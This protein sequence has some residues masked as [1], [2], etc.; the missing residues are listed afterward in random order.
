MLGRRL[1]TGKIV[2]ALPIR[3]IMTVWLALAAAVF[4]VALLPNA[5]PP[6]AWG[7]DKVVHFAVFMVLAAVPA[8]VLS[9]G[10]A[11]LGA[12]VFLLGIGLSIELAQSFIPGRVGSGA[13]FLADVLGVLVGVAVGRL[14]WRRFSV[15][16]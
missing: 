10:R 11:M 8:M 14:L 16:A 6:S 12:E 2:N 7:A 9:R 13:D 3:W 1:D 4:V 5:G 15:L